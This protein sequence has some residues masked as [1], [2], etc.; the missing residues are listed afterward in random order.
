MSFNPPLRFT[1]TMIEKLYRK[2][3]VNSNYW[4][5]IKFGVI[6]NELKWWKLQWNRI[7]ISDTGENVQKWTRFFSTRRWVIL[8]A[9]TRRKKRRKYSCPLLV[10]FACEQV[11][12]PRLYG[13]WVPLSSTHP[14]ATVFDAVPRW[15]TSQID[16]TLFWL[17]GLLRFSGRETVAIVLNWRVFVDLTNLCWTYG[18]FE[19]HLLHEES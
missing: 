1:N 10:K 4:I 17:Y 9:R 11:S 5:L 16:K 19:I 14:R 2:I 6:Y 8:V 18:P 13:I 3:V 15:W 7:T 12:R